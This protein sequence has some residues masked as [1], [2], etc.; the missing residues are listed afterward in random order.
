[1]R[2]KRKLRK[3]LVFISHSS[4]DN[5]IAEQIAGRVKQCGAQV[6]L[7]ESHLQSGADFEKEIV[8]QLNKSNE[9]LVLLTPWAMKRP[10]VWAE[11][12]VAWG[13]KINIIGV[14]HGLSAHALNKTSEATIFIK[15]RNL[16][17]L[18]DINKYFKELKARC[19]SRKI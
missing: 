13:R 10:Y 4:Q 3:W 15:A 17:Q 5:W 6:F 14:L 1:M 7:D 11:L 9:I 16:I 12:G 8:E 19:K 18:N 2:A